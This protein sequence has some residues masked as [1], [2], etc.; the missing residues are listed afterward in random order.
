M[1]T[2]KLADFILDQQELDEKFHLR[3][4]I[5]SSPRFQAFVDQNWDRVRTKFKNAKTYEARRDVLF[6]LNVPYVFLLNSEFDVEYEKFGTEKKRAPDFTIT[7]RNSIVF[8]I[9][10]TRIHETSVSNYYYD[11]IRS[12]ADSIL[13]FP[14]KLIIDI[15]WNTLNPDHNLVAILASSK[16]EIVEFI[17]KKITSE[18][19]K[20]VPE[21]S[22]DYVI[23]IEEFGEELQLT[24]FRPAEK[25]DTSK[26][27][28]L[29]ISSPVFYTQK[30][31]RIIGD[32]IFDK[33][34]QMVP[35]MINILF[36]G[37]ENT[38]FVKHDVTESI[39]SINQR[40]TEQD[41][42]FFT[43]K[44]FD[45]I[46]DFQKQAT[47]LSGILF[48]HG[49]HTLESARNIFLWLNH[50]ADFQVPSSLIHQIKTTVSIDDNSK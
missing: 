8:N 4:W 46:K 7:F 41:T 22:M 38:T 25:P 3:K 43:K 16:T 11:C 49:Y 39:R 36:I 47:K 28:C 33:L 27:P 2:N 10:V 34:S 14:S 18:E 17:K 5:E 24:L 42:A 31:Y 23:P 40:I 35:E 37:A 1:T 45:G 44:K 9:E 29:F 15:D 30:E 19:N 12:I 32:R 20:I 26:T 48:M 50:S 13:D 21:Q 6:E